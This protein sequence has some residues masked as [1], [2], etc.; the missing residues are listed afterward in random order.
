MNGLDMFVFMINKFQRDNL[1]KQKNFIFERKV[2]TETY[3]H[4]YSL[5]YVWLNRDTG[6]ISFRKNVR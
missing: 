2:S 6:Y 1:G 3:P 4:E 5:K